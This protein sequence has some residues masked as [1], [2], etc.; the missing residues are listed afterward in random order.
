[1]HGTGVQTDTGYRF[2]TVA[3]LAMGKRKRLAGFPKQLGVFSEAKPQ[4]GQKD[5]NLYVAVQPPGCLFLRDE[6]RENSAQNEL[7]VG[8]SR[9]AF[10]HSHNPQASCFYLL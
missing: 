10:T 5:E 1:M 4:S 9:Y 2:A 3:L 7:A 8:L 6:W